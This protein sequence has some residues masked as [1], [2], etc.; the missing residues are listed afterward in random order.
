MVERFVQ[1]EGLAN[2]VWSMLVACKTGEMSIVQAL[3]NDEPTLANCSWGYFTPIHFAVR[4]GHTEIV[5]LLLEYKAD[6]TIKSGLSWQDTPLQKALDRGLENTSS[7]LQ[8]HLHHSLNSNSIGTIIATLIKEHKICKLKTLIE[9]NPD[10]IHASDEQGNTALHWAVLTRKVNL[11]DLLIEKGANLEAKRADGSKAIHLAMEGDYFYRPNRDLPKESIQNHWY[12]LGYLVAKGAHYDVCIAAAI[13]D[14][15]FVRES[16]TKDPSLAN[17]KDSSD[18]TALYYAAKH[19]HVHVVKELLENGADPNQAE[20]NAPRGAAL[21]AAASSNYVSIAELLLE[22]GA[23][24]NAE[25]EASGNALYIAMYKGYVEMQE[26]LYASGGS[27]TLTAACALGKLDLVGE[28][29]AVNPSLANAD[30]DYGP[31]T[32][33]VSSE[34]MNIVQ[35][36]LNNKVDLNRP[37]YASNYMCYACR[38]SNKEMVELLLEQGADPNNS[39]WLGVSY[40]HLLALQGNTELAHLMLSYGADINAVDDEYCTTPLGWAV[41]YGKYEMVS[42][43][44]EQGADIVPIGVPDWATPKAWAERRR[45]E[46]IIELLSN[47]QGKS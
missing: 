31:L 6:A 2:N 47:R 45:D 34:S 14:A 22:Y 44:L 39:N 9:E 41:K 11:I 3:L 20:K 38:F 13:G 23:D 17:A 28:I 25:V 43:L 29:L 8:N 18:R 30:D 27:I 1:P 33:A 42:F 40:L 5:R 21:H 32:Q 36:L 26:L 7:L 35:L 19:G 4:E 46:A 16:L 12:L 24:I 37:W 15:E 10:A